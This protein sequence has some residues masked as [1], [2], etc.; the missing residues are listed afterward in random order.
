MT[1]SGKM[2][3]NGMGCLIFSGSSQQRHHMTYSMI[4]LYSDFLHWKESSMRAMAFVLFV[5][6][7]PAPRTVPDTVSAKSLQSCP[8]LCD[9]MD[10]SSPGSS[11]RGI[12]QARIL[13][14]ISM[15]F[16]RGSSQP[17]DQTCFASI[18]CI[19]SRV[20]YHSATLEAHLIHSSH[21]VNIFCVNVFILPPPPV[22]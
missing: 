18:S 19:G 6:V 10:W 1:S 4:C 21:L 17:R 22:L 8:T 16:S 20:L 9:P 11:V 3:G 5:A 2:F 12:F 14:W 15:S 13:E 7:V